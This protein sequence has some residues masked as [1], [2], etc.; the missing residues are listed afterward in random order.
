MSQ[1]L[2]VS[3]RTTPDLS[4]QRRQNRHRCPES[5]RYDSPSNFPPATHRVRRCL[6][7]MCTHA[8]PQ[9]GCI[10]DPIDIVLLKNQSLKPQ[11]YRCV[12][13]R[14]ARLSHSP[15]PN[16]ATLLTD[17]YH[18]FPKRLLTLSWTTSKT[19]PPSRRAPSFA[20]HLYRLAG[21]IFFATFP[22]AW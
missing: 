21:P 5:P 19:W 13:S 10:V 7:A 3:M 2:T 8:T 15:C 22:S 9:I 11:S 20:G 6:F 16:A 17:M 4:H 18:N 14:H 12:A 1:S